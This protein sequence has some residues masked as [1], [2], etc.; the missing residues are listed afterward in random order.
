MMPLL[1]RVY[2]EKKKKK[3]K[4]KK[5]MNCEAS[6]VQ[7]EWLCIYICQSPC[8]SGVAGSI[9]GFSSLLDEA[10]D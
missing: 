10:I 7:S 4:K 5:K 1:S 9:L 8:K 6:M 2:A 3:K